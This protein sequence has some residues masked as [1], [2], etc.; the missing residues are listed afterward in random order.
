MEPNYWKLTETK[1]STVQYKIIIGAMDCYLTEAKQKVKYRPE[2]EIVKAQDSI[3]VLEPR[4][5]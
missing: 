3:G 2:S 5:E 4:T 1:I